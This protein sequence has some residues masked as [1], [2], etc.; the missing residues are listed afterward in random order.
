MDLKSPLHPISLTEAQAVHAHS[1]V[2]E[3]LLNGAARLFGQGRGSNSMLLDYEPIWKLDE[4]SGPGTAEALAGKVLAM[5]KPDERNPVSTNT[6]IWS[7]LAGQ[8]FHSAG[9][10]LSH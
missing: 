6:F 1:R 2:N 10:N 4:A 7:H 8:L 5:V 9:P 3:L